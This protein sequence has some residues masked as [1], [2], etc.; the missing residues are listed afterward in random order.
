MNP[1]QSAD[2]TVGANLGNVGLLSVIA[3]MHNNE[4]QIT[5]RVETL[6]DILTD[7]CIPFEFLLLDFASTD[8]T[9]DLAGELDRLYPQIK[10]IYFPELDFN[11]AISAAIKSAGGDL[12]VILEEG[13]YAVQ[14]L[15]QLLRESLQFNSAKSDDSIST[16]ASIPNANLQRDPDQIDLSGRNFS[17]EPAPQPITQLQGIESTVLQR[18]ENWALALK[19]EADHRNN[20]NSISASEETP[21]PNSEMLPANEDEI[22][23]LDSQSHPS[24]RKLPKFITRFH[25]FI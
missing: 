10:T 15:T 13:P 5:L 9:T 17:T 20:L 11:R 12:I 18:L 4:G 22:R 7:A 14:Q 16:L 24:M 25:E 2:A 19:K 21:E 6:L 23:R 1:K 3:P 8:S